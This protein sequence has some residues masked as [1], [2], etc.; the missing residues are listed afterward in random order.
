MKRT[1]LV[2]ILIILSAA[3]VFGQISGGQRSDRFRNNSIEPDGFLGLRLGNSFRYA[4]E[5]FGEPTVQRN[6]SLEWHFRDADYEPYEALTVLGDKRKI[7]G[8]V[9]HLRPNRVQFTEMNLRPSQNRIGTFHA[10]RKYALGKYEVTI[11]VIGDDSTY[12][13]RIFLQAKEQ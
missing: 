7:N 5:L 8:F 11:L 3:A 9:A 6:G 12:A 10:T 4:E 13:R 1:T 2:L